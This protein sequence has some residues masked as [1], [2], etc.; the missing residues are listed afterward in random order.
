[1]CESKTNALRDPKDVLCSIDTTDGL[2]QSEKT[3]LLFPHSGGAI[4]SNAH[5]ETEGT[6]MTMNLNLYYDFPVP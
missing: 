5:P 2:P 3:S 6:Y 4:L 1:M